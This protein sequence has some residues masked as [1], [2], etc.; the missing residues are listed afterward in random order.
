MIYGVQ[1]LGSK[2]EYKGRLQ[3]ENL[4]KKN[5]Y[6]QEMSQGPLNLHITMTIHTIYI[7]ISISG[8]LENYILNFG[9]KFCCVKVPMI[10]S[11]IHFYLVRDK[12]SFDPLVFFWYHLFNG[13]SLFLT[14]VDLFQVLASAA[15][16]LSQPT[17]QLTT[18]PTPAKKI[19]EVEEETWQSIVQRRIETKTRRFS[20]GKSKPEPQATVNRFVPVAGHFFYPLMTK[21]DRYAV[22]LLWKCYED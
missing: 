1:A 10:D 22:I 4:K 7:C 14:I 9:N 8:L 20:K 18:N 5:S 12:G 2:D 19:V 15:Q 11:R 21:F 6:N 3:W 16:E 17:E 13:L